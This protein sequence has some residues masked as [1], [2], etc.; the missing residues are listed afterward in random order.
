MSL[1]P[2]IRSRKSAEVLIMLT[3]R[4]TVANMDGTE[5]DI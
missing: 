1:G 3:A 4:A 5:P 2:A